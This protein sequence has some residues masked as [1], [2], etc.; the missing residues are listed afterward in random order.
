MIVVSSFLPTLLWV[1]AC[2]IPGLWLGLV[3]RTSSAAPGTPPSVGVIVPSII[4]AFVVVVVAVIADDCT[5]RYLLVG[6]LAIIG[7]QWADMIW[8]ARTRTTT[9]RATVLILLWYGFWMANASSEK[10]MKLTSWRIDKELIRWVYLK[11]PCLQL[12]R[13]LQPLKL[14]AIYRRL[15]ASIDWACTILKLHTVCLAHGRRI[16]K[17]IHH[18][19]SSNLST[20]IKLVPVLLLRV[21]SCSI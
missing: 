4:P 11:L 2:P 13:W 9:I 18:S 1:N 17:L 10:V 7:V 12:G 6:V 20:V 16:T 5:W 14:L 19:A 8:Q 15:K 3:G 21:V